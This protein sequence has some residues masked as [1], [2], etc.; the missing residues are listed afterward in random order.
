MRVNLCVSLLHYQR[1]LSV[2][3]W[4]IKIFI[5]TY[6]LFI[7]SKC[8]VKT[9]LI[10]CKVSYFLLL[11]W[12][13]TAPLLNNPVNN[14]IDNLPLSLSLTLNNFSILF[15]CFSCWRW[16]SKCWLRIYSHYMYIV[17]SWKLQNIFVPRDS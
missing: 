17:P 14:A 6:L 8:F 15:W 2:L 5:E 12:F 9:T 3:F 16:T 1:K 13:Q 7:Y 11:I 10:L 4:H